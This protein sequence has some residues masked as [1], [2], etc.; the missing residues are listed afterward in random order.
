MLERWNLARAQRDGRRAGLDKQGGST[1]QYVPGLAEI[2]VG[3]TTFVGRSH[4]EIALF[5]AFDHGWKLLGDQIIDKDR[6]VIADALEELAREALSV[7]WSTLRE[8]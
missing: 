3:I 8:R 6:V 4:A 7:G 5:V 1:S 2:Q